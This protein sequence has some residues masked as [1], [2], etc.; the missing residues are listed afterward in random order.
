MNVNAAA[1]NGGQRLSPPQQRHSGL[2]RSLEDG[3]GDTRPPFRP[4]PCC[5]FLTAE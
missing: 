4:E 3:E 1:A 5:N 2:G